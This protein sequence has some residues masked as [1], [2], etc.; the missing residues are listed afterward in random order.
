LSLVVRDVTETPKITRPHRKC[1]KGDHYEHICQEPSG[2]LCGEQPCDQP[3]GTSWGPFF[4]PEHDVVRLARV[5]AGFAE[6]K[7]SLTRGV[8]GVSADGGEKQS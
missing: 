6:L 8:S 3:A 4:C 2:H 5:S 7:A 1:W